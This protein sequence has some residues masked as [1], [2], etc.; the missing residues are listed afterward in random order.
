[1]EKAETHK[2]SYLTRVFPVFISTPAIPPVP[3]SVR[4]SSII[5]SVHQVFRLYEMATPS[6]PSESYVLSRDYK[7]ASR[8]NYGHYLWQETLQHLIHPS[9]PLPAP[10]SSGTP[11][12]I[13]DVGCG[14]AAWARAAALAHPDAQV[15][16]FDVSLAQCPPAAW[17][18]RNMALREW[19]LFDE[20]ALPP[21]AVGRYDVVH[22]RLLFVVVRG[23]DP[24]PVI[25]ALGRL[26]RPGGRVQWE[27][28]DVRG[29]FVLRT[30]ED[31]RAPAMEGMRALLAGEGAWVRE[32]PALMAECGLVDARLWEYREREDLA[33]AFFENHLAKDEEMAET[34]M[35]G[36]EEG[37]K[38]LQRV[39]DMLVESK[40]GAVL[41]TPKVAC[42]ARKPEQQVALS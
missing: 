16:G 5:T 14:T 21:E 30:A 8:L 41:C 13:A 6:H 9:I 17:L 36:T 19:D 42:V 32:L 3:H 33:R 11:F 39:Q 20:A 1:M 24:R 15:D 29:S 28:L 10:S 4:A 26:A 38:A 34:T 25:R 27:E 23:G 31:V 35:K 40:R 22:A 2:V 7:A 12:R 37:R 18:P